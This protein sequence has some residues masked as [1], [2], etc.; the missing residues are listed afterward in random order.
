MAREMDQGSAAGTSRIAKGSQLKGDVIGGEALV[1]E[2]RVDGSVRLPEGTVTV[3]SGGLV[4]GDVHARRVIVEGRIEG[5]LEAVDDLTVTETGQVEGKISTP[6]LS[7]REGGKLQ[8]QVDMGEKSR[9]AAPAKSAPPRDQSK[10]DEREEKRQAQGSPSP[11][12]A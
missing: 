7:L 9:S 10:G 11:A 6:K 1:V 5:E 12:P 2:G 3:Q 8:G 4:S